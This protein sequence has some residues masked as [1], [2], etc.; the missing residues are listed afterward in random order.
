MY[1]CLRA[2]RKKQNEDI[3]IKFQMTTYHRKAIIVQNH[4]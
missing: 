4:L 1:I 3:L 2:V